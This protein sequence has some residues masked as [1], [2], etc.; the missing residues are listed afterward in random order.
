MGLITTRGS[1]KFSDGFEDPVSSDPPVINNFSASINPDNI[2][3][4]TL[5]FSVDNYKTLVLEKSF[6][7]ING[8]TVADSIL[9]TDVARKTSIVDNKNKIYRIKFKLTAQN[10]NGSAIKE[11]EPIEVG[12]DQ[13]NEIGRA[14]V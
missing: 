14:H 7:D 8:N 4:F 1:I 13:L 2:N 11:I 3:Q 6:I 12:T 10:K 9:N 5:Y